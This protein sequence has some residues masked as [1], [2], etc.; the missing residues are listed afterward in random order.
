VN[1]GWSDNSP[2]DGCL[3]DGLYVVKTDWNSPT[4]PGFNKQNLD[5]QNNAVITSLM[6]PGTM[7]GTASPPLF[8]NILIEDPPNVLFSLKILFPECNDQ[9]NPRYGNCKSVDL[10]L[11]SVLNLNIENLCTPASIQPNSIGFL[12]ILTNFT[13][14]FPSNIVNT[15]TNE[16]TLAGSMNIG[17]TNVIIQSTNGTVN[18]LTSANAVAVGHFIMNGTNINLTYGLSP[19]PCLSCL[20]QLTII[21]VHGNAVISW[22]TNFPAFSLEQ[23]TNLASPTIWITNSTAPVVISGLNVV[24]NP[25]SSKHQF[26]RLSQ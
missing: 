1:L 5:G 23:A 19:S 21:F 3:I 24:T 15:V 13:Y 17:L 14:D 8:R 4:G 6:V 10:T 11:P 12:N 25:I 9:D 22:P 18:P 16:F 20:P 26:Y 2:G 7:F